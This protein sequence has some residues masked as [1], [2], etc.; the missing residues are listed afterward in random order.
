[1]VSTKKKF[2]KYSH[3]HFRFTKGSRTHCLDEIPTLNVSAIT[4]GVLEWKETAVA[5]ILDGQTILRGVLALMCEIHPEST[6][7][8]TFEGS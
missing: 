3:C 1:M 6:K 2:S 8:E 5:Q 7:L 4:L